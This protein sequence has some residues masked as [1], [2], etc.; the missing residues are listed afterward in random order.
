MIGSSDL[1]LMR[2]GVESTD[3]VTGSGDEATRTKVVVINIRFSLSDGAILTDFYGDGKR[4]IIDLRRRDCI[5]GVR[6]G[7]EG[8]RVGGK[9]KLTIAPHLAYGKEGIPGRI[10]PNSP[11]LCEV[12]LLEVRERGVVKPE[13]YP[14]GLKLQIGNRGDLKTNIA[15]WQFGLDEDGRCGIWLTVPIQSMKWRHS[16][17]KYV[18][19]R[20]EPEDASTLFKQLMD[21]PARFP[22]Q[23][24]SLIHI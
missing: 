18:E 19:S 6:Y 13:D 2:P 14:P 15:R 16:R 21:L 1:S 17:M 20:M 5:A 23:C 9:R 10:P 12:E 7:I 8:M 3:I 4:I 11:L 24:L 22:G